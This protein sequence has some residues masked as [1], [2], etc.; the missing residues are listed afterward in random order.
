MLIINYGAAHWRFDRRLLRHYSICCRKR[1]RFRRCAMWRF[2]Q[3]AQ[4]LSCSNQRDFDEPEMR[5]S[6]QRSSWEMEA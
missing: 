2:R 4:S 6:S 5:C 3:Y 1:R